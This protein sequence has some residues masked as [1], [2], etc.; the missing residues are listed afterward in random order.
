[1]HTTPRVKPRGSQAANGT[2][3]ANATESE[4]S[5]AF[6]RSPAGK[7]KVRGTTRYGE[8]CLLAARRPSATPARTGPGLPD[9]HRAQRSSAS[10]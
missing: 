8:L 9:L 10:A 2:T 7:A 1:M 5:R 3:I 4:V 6:P